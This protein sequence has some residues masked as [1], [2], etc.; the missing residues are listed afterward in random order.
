MGERALQEEF[1]RRVRRRRMA[2]GMIQ[3]TLSERTGMPQ[4]HISY[5]EKGK[6][7]SMNLA[8]LVLLADVLQ[9]S[10]DYLLAR[11]DEAGEVPEQFL[12]AAVG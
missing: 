3:K 1:G 7:I 10:V 6:Q 9:T 11:S 12:Y 5:L 4:S 8:K 2:L